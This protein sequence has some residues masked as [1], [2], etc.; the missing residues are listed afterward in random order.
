MISQ[1]YSFNATLAK[2][3]TTGELCERAVA[4]LAAGPWA[5]TTE[6][7]GADAV[8][9][10]ASF[11]WASAG[12]GA[13]EGGDFY[14]M[15]GEVTDPHYQGMKEGN[16][17]GHQGMEKRLARV[18]REVIPRWSCMQNNGVVN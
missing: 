15:G 18:R 10:G 5:G 9:G 3:S 2:K 17:G 8:V 13:W 4:P 7:A 12:A 6:L 1:I 14:G 16:R 11:L